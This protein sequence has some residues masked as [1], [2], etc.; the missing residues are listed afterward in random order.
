[1]SLSVLMHFSTGIIRKILA[2]RFWLPFSRLSYQIYLIHFIVI[3]YHFLAQRKPINFSHYDHLFAT[4]AIIVMTLL[5][6]FFSFLVF[7]APFAALMKMLVAKLAA[8]AD[9]GQPHE[10]PEFRMTI[11]TVATPDQ[12]NFVVPAAADHYNES[13]ASKK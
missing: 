6:A 11:V 8:K 1:M 3:Y 2:S 4:A 12:L 5:L 13:A 10:L 9:A 7:E